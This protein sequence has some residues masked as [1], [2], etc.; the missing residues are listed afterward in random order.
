MVDIFKSVI[1]SPF[2]YFARHK[3]ATW[4]V[5]SA[6][7]L[8]ILGVIRPGTAYAL[9]EIYSP[10]TEYHEISAEINA[11]HTFDDDPD[12]D[13]AKTQEFVLEYGLTPRMMLAV[14]S[15][16][17]NDPGGKLHLA[18][19]AIEGRF[20]FFEQGE[21]WL[22]IGLLTAYGHAVRDDGTD[23]LEMK[24]LLQKDTGRITHT[25]N[26]GF[27]QEI[28]ASASGGPNYVLL[29]NSRYRYSEYAQPGIELQSDLG[30]THDLGEF[31]DHEHYLGPALYGRLFGH[32][33]YQVGYLVGL[34]SASS[35]SAARGLLEYESYF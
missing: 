3:S 23:S 13:N 7:I 6:V 8:P 24:L 12:K 10:I 18:D 9:D 29:W 30:E 34:T 16:Y 4:V 33:K 20:Q 32:L 28:G 19:Y 5:V 14:S 17:E 35:Q 11:S 1:L 15:G 21:K 2:V 27:E 26:I 31:D 22:D 25:V